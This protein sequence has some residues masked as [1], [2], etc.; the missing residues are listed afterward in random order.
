[1][2]RILLLLLVLLVV[3]L[4][5]WQSRY[6]SRSWR[7]PLYVAI[8]PIAAD[9]SPVTSRYLADLDAG[10]FTP[11]DDFFIREAARYGLGEQRPV[12]TRLRS[13]LRERPPQRAS[14]AGLLS[15]AWWSLR[16][17]F[18][19]WRVSGHVD[20]PED[21]RVPADLQDQYQWNLDAYPDRVVDECVVGASQREERVAPAV[22]Q[23]E[24][25]H[26][27]AKGKKLREGGRLADVAPTALD[28]MGLAK[29]MEMTG[30]SLILDV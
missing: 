13:E 1:M 30:T 8:Y 10:R 26:R 15:T 2:L 17:R 9:D 3:A 19:A 22:L 27:D 24:P 18:W 28:M 12:T 5:S 6:R 16:L 20:E 14:D 29:P 25:G 11:I 4:S 21:I 7:V 23:H